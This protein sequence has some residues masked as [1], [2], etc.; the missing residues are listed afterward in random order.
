MALR[1]QRQVPTIYFGKPGKL[2]ALPWP[3]GGLEASY[4][5][6]TYDFVTGSGMHQVSSLVVGSRPYT[7]QW[8]ALH[9][10]NFAKVSRYRIGANGPGPWVFIDPSAPNLLPANVGAATGLYSDATD[11]VSLG[12]TSGTVTSNPTSTFIHRTDGY[13]SLRWQF[14]TG[15]I[16]TNPV[17]GV[18]PLYRNWYGQPVVPN[19]PYAWSAWCRVDG[20]IETSAT[21]AMKL[22]WLDITGAQISESTGG[23]QVVTSAWQRLS[24]LATA[25]PTAAYVDC[26]WYALGSSLAVNGSFYFDEIMLEQDTVVNDWSPST[27]IRPVDILDLGEGVPFEGRFRVNPTMT[28]RE[29]SK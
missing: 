24:C 20:T 16:I 15:P 22:R 29:L 28:L 7:V 27:G 6:Q 18:S 26:R 25:P 12:G 2:V 19:L 1:G 23:D 21:L 9:V 10:D 8:E 13:R 5:R 17:L 3:A 11:L 4:E 14:T